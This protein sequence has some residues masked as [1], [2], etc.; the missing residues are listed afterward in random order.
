MENFSFILMS[1]QWAENK[2]VLRAL[3]VCCSWHTNAKKKLRDANEP[4]K[5]RCMFYR[6]KIK[7]LEGADDKTKR[8]R[9]LPRPHSLRPFIDPPLRVAASVCARQSV[10]RVWYWSS[11]CHCHW[12][13]GGLDSGDAG[14][15]QP[16]AQ[17]GAAGREGGGQS[18]C[19][20]FSNFFLD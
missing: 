9:P 15:R 17:T 4:C 12:P 2:R 3:Q 1:R 18:F 16:L 7:A 10:P 8:G 5:Q 20:F 6:C 19:F 13:Q 11:P 14:D